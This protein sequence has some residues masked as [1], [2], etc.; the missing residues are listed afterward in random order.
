MDHFL[1]LAVLKISHIPPH[2][3]LAP[4]VSA[5]MEQVIAQSFFK[6]TLPLFQIK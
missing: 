5:S 3:F 1:V 4:S 6:A 2:G